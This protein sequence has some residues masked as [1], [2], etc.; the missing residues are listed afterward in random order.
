MKEV[1][2]S[3]LLLDI[4]VIETFILLDKTIKRLKLRLQFLIRD[5]TALPGCLAD[6]LKLI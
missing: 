6:T 2:C 1:K 5:R 4:F 3:C